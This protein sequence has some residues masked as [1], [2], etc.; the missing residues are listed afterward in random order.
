MSQF[1]VIC[2]GDALID[3]F[4]F[5]SNPDEHFHESEQKREFCFNLGAKIPVSDSKFYPGGDASNVSV[6]LSRLGLRSALVGETGD[7]MFAH[8]IAE[9]L[10]KEHVVLD[11]FK[12][13]PHTPA[14]FSVNIVAMQDRTILSRHIKRQHDISFESAQTQWVYLT[15]LGEE[16][17]PMYKKVLG[18]VSQNNIKLAFNPGS[19]QLQAGR[20][21][22]INI[23]KRTDV[24]FVNKEEAEKI[25]YGQ[26]HMARSNESIEELLKD[27]QSLGP[28]IVSVTDGERGSYVMDEQGK[29]YRQGTI[30]GEYVQKTGVGDA[31]ASGFLGSLL[32]N[33][34]DIQKAMV[35]GATN[36]SS[37]I[38]HLGAQGGLLKK[39][40]IEKNI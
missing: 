2:V 32:Y 8:T 12:Q 31:Y 37:V 25:A 14:T 21:S 27:T 39:E 26:E 16:W 9:G 10:Q 24:L 29:M 34:E 3:I 17:L 35:W 11:F 7:D 23:L 33:K 13:T 36:A 22:F 6:G 5:L 30:P 40:D 20:E 38:A 19:K 15:S 4:L 18:Y 1:D 28:K